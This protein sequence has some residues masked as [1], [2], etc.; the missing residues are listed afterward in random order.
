MLIFII[1]VS[2]S[3]LF[4]T[5]T[6]FQFLQDW[7]G[8]TPTLPLSYYLRD[9][10][11]VVWWLVHNL[12]STLLLV[13]VVTGFITLLSIFS[14]SVCLGIYF[15]FRVIV[16]LRIVV[17]Y[18]YNWGT[19]FAGRRSTAVDSDSSVES[20]RLSADLVLSS[21]KELFTPQQSISCPVV[22]PASTPVSTCIAALPPYPQAT[23]ITTSPRAAAIQDVSHRLFLEDRA[24]AQ[25]PQPSGIVHRYSHRL[26]SQQ[27]K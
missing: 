22:V 7:F 4:A 25:D 9:T 1:F 10:T 11:T 20:A 27:Q 3:V 18:T 17:A 15:F 6:P 14:G 23:A 21:R 16:A 26:Q 19:R 2:T 12:P 24:L 13:L 8:E 5:A